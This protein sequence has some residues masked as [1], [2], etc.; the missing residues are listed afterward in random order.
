MASTLLSWT[1]MLENK[2]PI[3]CSCTGALCCCPWGH[4]WFIADIN[5]DPK[6]ILHCLIL[7]IRIQWNNPS[8]SIKRWRSPINQMR[9]ILTLKA[10]FFRLM[11]FPALP[12]TWRSYRSLRN[13]H[14]AKI[15]MLHCVC[16]NN[17]KSMT[18]FYPIQVAAIIKISELQKLH[19]QSKMMH[20]WTWIGP[21]FRPRDHLT[22]LHYYRL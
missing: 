8:C 21:F 18:L 1:Y 22:G 16:S 11:T 2:G 3:Y 12:K 13:S 7:C 19:R 5:T 17:E 4:C 15:G 10:F 6:I 20:F 14:S 9:F